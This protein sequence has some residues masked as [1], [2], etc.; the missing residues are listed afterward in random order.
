MW[1]GVRVLRSW[2]ELGRSIHFLNARGYRFHSNP[3]KCWDLHLISEF[4]DDLERGELVVDLGATNLGAVR[5]LHQMAFV[6]FEATI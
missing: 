4:V 5:L 2:S 1:T 3:M 6:G